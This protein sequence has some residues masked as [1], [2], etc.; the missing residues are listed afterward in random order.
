[1][2]LQEDQKSLNNPSKMKQKNE[3]RLTLL[4]FKNTKTAI[5]Q[6]VTAIRRH[7]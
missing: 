1:M 7:I 3:G 4:N 6:C 2:E 5:R